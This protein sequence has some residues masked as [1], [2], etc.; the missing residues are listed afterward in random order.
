[1]VSREE[2]VC[3]YRAI[4]G[5]EPES[6]EVIERHRSAENFAA[7]RTRFLQSPEF[8]R[9]FGA[10]VAF[11]RYPLDHSK[12]KVDDDATPAQLAACLEKTRLLGRIL[13]SPGLITRC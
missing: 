7:L 6:E 11:R 8:L 5:R 12:M 2:V 10:K 13:A 4:L 9:R 3:C 1:M